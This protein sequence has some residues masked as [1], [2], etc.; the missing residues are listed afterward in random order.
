MS[1]IRCTSKTIVSVLPFLFLLIQEWIKETEDYMY[2]YMFTYLY[3]AYKLLQ[4]KNKKKKNTL[5]ENQF[6]LHLTT[7][8]L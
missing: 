2:R 8:V 6:Y 7:L 5:N 1:E 3:I 4:K